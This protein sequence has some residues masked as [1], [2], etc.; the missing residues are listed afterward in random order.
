[1]NIKLTLVLL[2][3]ISA[4]ISCKKKVNDSIDDFYT[5]F[6]DGKFNGKMHLK[7]NLCAYLN[8]YL[9]DLDRNG[10]YPGTT[11]YFQPSLSTVPNEDI[12]WN[13]QKLKN[14]KYIIYSKR[15]NG[16]Y[17]L[18]T[19][20]ETPESLLG[21]NFPYPSHR[22]FIKAVGAT[23][24]LDI[25]EFHQFQITEMTANYS[26]LIKG[27]SEFVRFYYAY[28]KKPGTNDPCSST[29]PVSISVGGPVMTS[30]E[31]QDQ[32]DGNGRKWTYV[33]VGEFI[34]TKVP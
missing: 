25:S 26:F 14:G 9:I 11:Q 23:L 24:P 18:W 6:V 28:E 7:T 31:Y 3:C 22:M 4:L 20:Q 27:G 30:L 33:F 34:Y 8:R 13:F 32:L 5:D 17:Y 1:M 29:T 19:F 10:P 12:P 2:L 15:K 21:P 16:G